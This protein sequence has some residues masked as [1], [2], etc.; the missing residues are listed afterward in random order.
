MLGPPGTVRVCMPRPVTGSDGEGL[1]GLGEIV[2][3][4]EVGSRAQG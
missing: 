3:D 4:W 2:G 1:C